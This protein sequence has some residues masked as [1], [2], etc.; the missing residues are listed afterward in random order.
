[1]AN[2]PKCG[3]KLHLYNWKQH[4]PHC[5]ANIFVYD[6]Q[7]RLMREADI[8][9]VEHYHFQRKIDNVKGAFIGSKLAITRIFT[10][11]LPI[12][13][14]FLPIVSGSFNPD[15]FDYSGKV[16]L[17]TVINESSKI[18]FDAWLSSLS[19]GADQKMFFTAAVCLALSLVLTLVHFILNTLA[20]SPKGKVRNLTQDILLLALSAAALF[21]VPGKLLAVGAGAYLYF[22][23]QVVNVAVDIAT[24]QKGIEIKHKQ[25][26][27]GGIPIEEYFEMQEKGMSREEIRAEQYRRLQAIQDAE[28]AELEEKEKKMKE[29]AENG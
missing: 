28:E 6:L 12:G 3:E 26:F 9:E 16:T 11:I 25:C 18:R 13:A 1:M 20:C 21:C 10:S 29:A 15:V 8:A 4:C 14:L 17:L 23:L 2:C 5:G 7:E 19:A 27:V 24:L 22:A